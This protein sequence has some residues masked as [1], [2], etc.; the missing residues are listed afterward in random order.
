MLFK[1]VTLL[2]LIILSL[3]NSLTWTTDVIGHDKWHKR[4]LVYNYTHYYSDINYP[5]ITEHMI[6]TDGSN[7]GY[8]IIYNTNMHSYWYE[9]PSYSETNPLQKHHTVIS[10]SG[11]H[12]GYTLAANAYIYILNPFYINNSEPYITT[13]EE[14]YTLDTTT[15]RTNYIVNKQGDNFSITFDIYGYLHIVLQENHVGGNDAKSLID[16]RIRYIKWDTA[17][18]VMVDDYYISDN[19]SVLTQTP[20]IAVDTNG[21]AHIVYAYNADT[22]TFDWGLG[23]AL[24]T[25]DQGVVSCLYDDPAILDSNNYICQS[26]EI[27]VDNYNRP[28]I[29]AYADNT[30]MNEV[31][32]VYVKANSLSLSGV[33]WSSVNTLPHPG[34]NNNECY[35]PDIKFLNGYVHICYE[36]VETF[37]C[38]ENTDI[39][40]INSPIGTFSPSTPECLT[41]GMPDHD[42]FFTPS[43][44]VSDTEDEI[45]VLFAAFQSLDNTPWYYYLTRATFTGN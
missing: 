17:N 44:A 4:A 37:S 16:T 33:N 39:Y 45:S 41:T 2:V 13:T 23:Y 24:L 26:P 38:Y 20:R 40:Y 36:A 25:E 10:N 22:S 34:L 9:C 6:S 19:D 8:Y 12:K 3:C 21:D 42:F 15:F 1:K 31:N 11:I 5:V 30:T 29:V 28:H 32:I 43:I 14:Y 7:V 35:E 18:D 27:T